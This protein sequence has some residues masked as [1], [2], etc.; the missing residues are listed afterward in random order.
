VGEKESATDCTQFAPGATCQ[1]APNE[2][3]GQPDYFCG[4]AAECNPLS[5]KPSCDG[6]N[7]KVCALGK[8]EIIACQALGFVR[9]GGGTDSSSV[10]S[11]AQCVDQAYLDYAQQQQGL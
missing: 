9:C 6:D 3:T 10:V 11:D 1:Q 7:L 5:W 8:I 2:K 4:V